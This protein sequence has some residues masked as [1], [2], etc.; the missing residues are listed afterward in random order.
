[1]F[2]DVSSFSRAARYMKTKK[3]EKKKREKKPN[4]Y[5]D[6]SVRVHMPLYMRLSLRRAPF[7]PCYPH[8]VWP[9]CV[10]ARKWYNSEN[11]VCKS[12]ATINPSV[13]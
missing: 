7:Y 10:P 1:M 6:L 5:Y 3:K 13:R 12:T 11:S 9:I 8:A 2:A 4:V